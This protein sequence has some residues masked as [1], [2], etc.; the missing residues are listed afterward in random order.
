VDSTPLVEPDAIYL[1]AYDGSLY[2][3]GRDSGEVEWKSDNVGGVSRPV[4]I[5][6]Y[7]IAASTRG[8]LFAIKKSDGTR[9][10]ELDLRREDRAGSVSSADKIRLKTPSEPI[11]FGNVVLTASNDGFLYAVDPRIGSV[12]WRYDPGNGATGG[13]A[14]DERRIYFVANGGHLFALGAA[15]S[16]LE[17]APEGVLSNAP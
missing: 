3:L 5:G 13:F 17:P 1:A 16:S 4:S 6:D 9:A 14:R 7:L 8:Y 12:V 15:S 10:W 2:R 11:L